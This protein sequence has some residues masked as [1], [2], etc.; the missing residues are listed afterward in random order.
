VSLSKSEKVLRV[1]KKAFSE[2][3]GCKGYF[4]SIFRVIIGHSSVGVA[5]RRDTH[6]ERRMILLDK[7][8]I[9]HDTFLQIVIPIFS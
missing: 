8:R 6:N 1:G 9:C 4:I 2:L 5:E 7:C 3:L